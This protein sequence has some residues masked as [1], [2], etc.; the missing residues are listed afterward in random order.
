MFSLLHTRRAI[1]HLSFG[2][3]LSI[4]FYCEPAVSL[5]LSSVSSSRDFRPHANEG[6]PLAPP[7]LF[8]LFRCLRRRNML[9]PVKPAAVRR[10]KQTRRRRASTGKKTRLTGNF[11]KSS[12][13]VT[14]SPR[15]ESTAPLGKY[16]TNE[17]AEITP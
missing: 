12:V 4:S 11:T 14:S 13:V 16:K 5:S 17:S 3:C 15:T 2:D 10:T 6:A 1:F 9:F 7:F 8:F